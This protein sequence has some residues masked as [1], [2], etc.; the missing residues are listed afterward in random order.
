MFNFVPG[1]A[2]EDAV[3]LAHA[4]AD[5]PGDPPTAFTRFTG[6]RVARTSAITNESWKFGRVVH[7]RN[8]LACSLRDH[9]L[10]FLLPKIGPGQV[11]RHASFDVGPLPA[12]TS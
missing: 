5:H 3:V 11:T 8:R 7:Y 10:G 4:V 1:Q 6:E 9:L 12:V 2:I